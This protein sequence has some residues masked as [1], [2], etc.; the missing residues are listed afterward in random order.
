MEAAREVMR[1]ATCFGTAV[2]LGG[3]LCL[4]LSVFAIVGSLKIGEPSTCIVPKGC[5]ASRVVT[6]GS[7]SRN[8]LS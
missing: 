5:Y 7:Y 1:W 4:S 2:G 8:A 3:S 6:S